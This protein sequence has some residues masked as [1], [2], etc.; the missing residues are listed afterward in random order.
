M[1]CDISDSGHPLYR[2]IAGAAP[3][4]LSKA[5][6]FPPTP[7]VVALFRPSDVDIR[8]SPIP[9][10]KK[11]GLQPVALLSQAPYEDVMIPLLVRV[12]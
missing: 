8:L 11:H 6:F 3:T 12:P 4:N 2:A 1:G 5:A 7:M 9:E 10:E